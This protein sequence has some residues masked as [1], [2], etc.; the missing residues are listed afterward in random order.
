MLILSKNKRIFMLY[1]LFYIL[2]GIVSSYIA[3]NYISLNSMNIVS[4]RLYT[5]NACAFILVNSTNEDVELLL[6]NIQSNQILWKEDTTKIRGVF[7]GNGIN[8]PLIS[9][10]QF[11]W[12]NN[13]MHKT[14][15]ILAG[16]NVS[17][18]DGYDII[19]TLGLP[20][21]NSC[22]D[23]YLLYPITNNLPTADGKWVLDGY[24]ISKTLENIQNTSLSKKIYLETSEV[25][26]AFRAYESINIDLLFWLTYFV[27][28]VCTFMVGLVW[29]DKKKNYISICRLSGVPLN[30]IVCQMIKEKF[31]LTISAIISGS[32][33][34]I[35]FIHDYIFSKSVVPMWLIFVGFLLLSYVI[36]MIFIVYSTRK[37]VGNDNS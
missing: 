20:N 26:G 6:D 7:Y 2:I 9:G 16:E 15:Q 24:N 21:K 23:E 30:K 8:L 14:N 37:W 17:L 28:L 1:I 34:S 12:K 22:L 13:N 5:E 27:V 32:G 31:Y 25:Q 11:S 19:G 4:N 36:N 33:Y 18:K 3:G 10:N 35:L 29:F